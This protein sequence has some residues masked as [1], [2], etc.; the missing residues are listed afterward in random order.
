VRDGEWIA[1][2]LE[3][4]PLTP[5]FVPPPEIAQVILA[6]TGGDMSHFPSSRAPGGLGRS[7]AGD[8]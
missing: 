2:L 6:E 4:G 1:Q 5:S 3:H 8:L 7:S